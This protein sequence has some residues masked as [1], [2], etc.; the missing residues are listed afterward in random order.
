MHHVYETKTINYNVSVLY[1]SVL[2]VMSP[3]FRNK[4]IDDFLMPVKSVSLYLTVLFSVDFILSI[5]E[6]INCRTQ[7]SGG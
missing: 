3:L 7:L 1:I 4:D 6:L 5:I 2:F